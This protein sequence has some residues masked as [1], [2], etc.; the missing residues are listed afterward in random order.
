MTDLIFPDLDSQDVELFSENG[1]VK[2]TSLA[3]YKLQS[4]YEKHYAEEGLS[5][6]EK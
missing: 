5:I 2:V 4:I 1:M 3:I 6:S